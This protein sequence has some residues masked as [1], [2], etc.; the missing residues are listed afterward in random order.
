MRTHRIVAWLLGVGLYG[1]VAGCG[2]GSSSSPAG[3]QPTEAP[4]RGGPGDSPLPPELAK[5]RAVFEKQDCGNC[6]KIHGTAIKGKK[7]M[8]GPDLGTVGLDRSHTAAWIADHIK[9]PQ[10]HKA[11]SK[12]PKYKDKI[13]DEDLKDLSNYLAS[14]K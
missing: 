6:H 11:M 4:T 12:M 7:G 2:G 8:M 5:G 13:S 1:F 10:S 14:L 3:T 9:D